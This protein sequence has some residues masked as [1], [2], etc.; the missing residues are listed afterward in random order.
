LLRWFALPLAISA[1][2]FGADFDWGLPKG[3][4][5]PAVPPGNRMSA[6]KVELGRYLFYEF[7]A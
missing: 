3:F 6:V 7:S 1:G 4:P 5:R 2:L